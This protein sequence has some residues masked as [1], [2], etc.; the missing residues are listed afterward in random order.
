VLHL[1]VSDSG[2]G[3]GTTKPG[4]RGN[5]IGLANTESRLQQ[6]YG[7]AHSIEYGHSADGGASV[8]IAIPF[9][10]PDGTG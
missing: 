9:Q 10:Q 5:R 2:P 1:K 4:P 8:A 7:D 3:F 6:L